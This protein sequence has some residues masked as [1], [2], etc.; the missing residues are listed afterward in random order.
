MLAEHI[1]F[2]IWVVWTVV[3][4]DLGDVGIDVS[5]SEQF[6]LI[7]APNLLGSLLRIP[8][9]FAMP[10]FGGRAWTT[11]SAGLCWCRP[12]SRT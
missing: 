10:R 4:L 11:I 9:S 6:I 5:L 3:V 7:L 2:A 1:G 12:D 8:Y